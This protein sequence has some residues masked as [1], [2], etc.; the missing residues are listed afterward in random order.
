[1]LL[2]SLWPTEC[3][4]CGVPTPL[5]LCPAC[6]MDVELRPV[7]CA[8]VEVFAIASY[9]TAIGAVLRRA[10]YGSGD[11]RAAVALGE[12]LSAR[13]GAFIGA[14]RSV[15]P[16]PSP[17]TRRWTRGFSAPAVF[18]TPV[19]KVVRARVVHALAMAPGPPQ[20]SLD[21]ARRRTNLDGRLRARRAVSGR[22]LLVDD[23]ITT[24]STARACSAALRAAGAED[25]V[26]LCLVATER[27]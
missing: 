3:L 2:D 25:V 6:T 14:F 4:G 22:V 21:A 17:W 1:M 16:V 7:P 5:P 13:C 11:R 18:A 15:V 24:G 8:G 27:T 20:A 23:A 9:R 26:V 12:L 19:A 10:K